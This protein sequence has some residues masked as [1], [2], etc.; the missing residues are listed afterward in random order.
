LSAA[1]RERAIRF[2]FER[3][4]FR[5]V[6][7]HAALRRVLAAYVGAA[8]EELVFEEGEFGK[9]FLAHPPTKIRLSATH[10]ED[11]AAFAVA[12]DAEVGIDLEVVERRLSDVQSLAE[13]CFSETEC[14]ALAAAPEA[15]R[16]A[17]FLRGWT[18]KEAYLKAIGLGLQ[19]PPEEVPVSFDDVR[20]AVNE[21]TVIP[22]NPGPRAIAALVAPAG[23]E[24]VIRERWLE[25]DR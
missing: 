15:D 13:S 3:D 14:R 21:W 5:Y 6:A 16:K 11:M 2:H 17:V 19:V 23:R 20:H 22:L 4:R 25:G 10:S 9:P 7:A 8:P 24:W 1:E 18:R 12:V